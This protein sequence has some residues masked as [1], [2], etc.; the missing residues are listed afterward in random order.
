[1]AAGGLVLATVGGLVLLLP[2]ST[3]LLLS[4]IGYVISM[5]LFTI[6]PD[7]PNY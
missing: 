1:M 4:G 3:L 6:M 2:G 5:L 7:S